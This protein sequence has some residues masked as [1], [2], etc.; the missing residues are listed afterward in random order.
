M[1]L[2][3]DGNI[4]TDS[5]L[6]LF[7]RFLL[8]IG[9]FFHLFENNQFPFKGIHSADISIEYKIAHILVHLY[10]TP[11]SSPMSI[12]NVVKQQK[13]TRVITKLSS[14]LPPDALVVSFNTAVPPGP[15]RMGPY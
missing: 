1:K 4:A 11:L 8:E 10:L 15:R 12:P 9:K 5:K 6:I 14:S 3:K 13:R 7:P 2:Q